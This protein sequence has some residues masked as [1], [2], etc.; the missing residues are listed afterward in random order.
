M[1]PS[2]TGPVPPAATQSAKI[3]VA[4]VI[5]SLAGSGGA[6]NRL[7]EEIVAIG[8]RFDHLV[9]RLFERDFL[10][11]RLEAAGV[12]VVGLGFQ[13]RHAGRSWPLAAARLRSVLRD[14]RPDVV[15][16]S[17]FTGNLVGQLASR[18]LALPVLSSFNR[19]GD[20]QLQ[21]ALQPGV[22]S[23]RGRVMQAIARRAGRGGDV[24]YRAVGE[25]ARQTNSALF[26]VPLDRI[27]VVPRGIDVDGTA[28][29]S[30]RT[31]FGLPADGP[32]IVNVARLVPEKGQHLLVEAFAR[33]HTAYPRAQL[34]I[35][36]APGSAEPA[37]QE[38]IDRLGVE[39][40]AHLLGFRAD[41]RALIAAADA[42][43][44]SS[45]SEGSP[46]VVLEAL[47]L[48]TPVVAF[49]IPPVAELTDGGRVARLAPAG[50]VHG[51]AELMLAAL[52]SPDRTAEIVAGRQWARRF[53]L[54]NVARDLGN[55]L[56]QRARRQSA[57]RVRR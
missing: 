52:G 26:D 40:A 14:W 30:S 44:L 27:S 50:S 1:I 16:T 8:D 38:A 18:S 34:A 17:L 10:Q 33:V 32:L 19:T 49:D 21:R 36:G 7:V 31:D 25:Y 20:L 22:A 13:A 55:L 43:V 11:G 39:T 47:A 12:P 48:G 35:A 5:D 42:F 24:H 15:H 9:V 57:V 28:V 46:G 6:E 3:R 29:S 45:V 51:L 2:E 56:E 41:A 37:V 4:H 53:N 54:A 23:W